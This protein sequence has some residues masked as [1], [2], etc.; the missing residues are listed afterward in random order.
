MPTIKRIGPYRIFFFAGDR[1]EPPHVHVERDRKAA[2]FWLNPVRL[3]S[4][5]RFRPQEIR[6]IQRI[7]E[8]YEQEFLETWHEYFSD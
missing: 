1:S 8:D 2:K 4:S 5:G 3:Q 6:R 7:V